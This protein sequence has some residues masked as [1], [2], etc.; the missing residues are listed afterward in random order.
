MLT[1]HQQQALKDPKLLTFYSSFG[2]RLKT[3]R[4]GKWPA[5]RE[6]WLKV[7]PK[8]QCCGRNTSIQVH[9]IKPVHL[10]PELE[11]DEKNLITLC[12]FRGFPCHFVVGHIM[13][14]MAWNPDVIKLA[15]H[16]LDDTIVN[17]LFKRLDED[18]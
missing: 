6:R 7:Q 12:E 1:A 8:C 15:Q 2:H 4:S 16:Y 13:N 5:L 17:K 9:H 18:N 11:L 3:K 10:Y 14:W